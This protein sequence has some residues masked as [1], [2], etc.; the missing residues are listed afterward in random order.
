MAEEIIACPSEE[1]TIEDTEVA[2]RRQ[3]DQW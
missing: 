1:R 2:E 3:G